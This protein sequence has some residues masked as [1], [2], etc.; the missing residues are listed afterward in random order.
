[1]RIK[2]EAEKGNLRITTSKEAMI[3]RHGYD[4]DMIG[5]TMNMKTVGPDG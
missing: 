5:I 3:Q 1:M 4:M 2:Q